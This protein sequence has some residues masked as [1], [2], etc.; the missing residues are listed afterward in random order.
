ML[1]NYVVKYLSN[2]R[3][4]RPPRESNEMLLIGGQIVC[5]IV[6]K[7]WSNHGRIVVYSPA[8]AAEERGRQVP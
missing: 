3:G 6:V 5:Q 4:D 2:R 7:S 8:A 1:V